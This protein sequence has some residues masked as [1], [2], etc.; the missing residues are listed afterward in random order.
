MFLTPTLVVMGLLQPPPQRSSAPQSNAAFSDQYCL[1]PDV[2]PETQIQDKL[3][4]GTL[5]SVPFF[6]PVAAYFL[7]PFVQRAYHDGVDML[8]GH[9]WY[10][11][12]GGALQIAQLLPVTNGLVVPSVSV[13]FGTLAAVTIQS[14][15]QRQISIRAL[16]NKE[17]CALRS[18][19]AASRCVFAGTHFDAERMR[20]NIL[21]RE[22]CTRLIFESR[23]G[24]DLEALERLGASDSELDGVAETFYAARDAPWQGPEA[25]PLRALHGG[26]TDFTA[27]QL[28]RDL[29]VF[30]SD[31]LAL[32][33]TPFPTVHWLILTTLGGSILLAYLF[34]TD[35]QV[36]LPPYLPTLLPS[37]LSLPFSTFVTSLPGCRCLCRSFSSLTTCSYA[38]SSRCSPLLSSPS[39]RSA[40]IWP[41]PF[42]A[43]SASHPPRRSSCA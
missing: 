6:T 35:V 12:Y 34:E 14:L 22:Y 40:P 21:L 11:Q 27:K 24:I 10:G 4:D 26:N 38:T 3:Y 41:T 9:T 17:A 23:L 39:P 7:Y 31:R 33:Q 16:L 20:I 1:L 18:L 32:L 25:P 5:F 13:A 43:P 2:L 42:A 8:S 19:H 29:Q 37:C 15:R 28:V 36:K 30:R